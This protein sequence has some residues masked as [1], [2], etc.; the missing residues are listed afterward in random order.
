MVDKK[1]LEEVEEVEAE[2]EAEESIEAEEPSSST[3]QQRQIALLEEAVVHPLREDINQLHEENLRMGRRI[4]VLV[5]SHVEMQRLI[6]AF[7]P[8]IDQPL[9]L[10]HDVEFE[11]M[12]PD[13]D[14]RVAAQDV[15]PP[16]SQFTDA[17]QSALDWLN[18]RLEQ[19]DL[20][21]VSA[22][23]VRGGGVYRPETGTLTVKASKSDR[24][25]INW[26]SLVVDGF[27][28]GIT[29]PEGVKFAE[30]DTRL[31]GEI[32]DKAFSPRG[33]D[34][35]HAHLFAREETKAWVANIQELLGISKHSEALPLFWRMF[36]E[37]LTPGQL[38]AVYQ[39]EVAE[40]EARQREREA[41]ALRAE[42]MPVE[43]GGRL[44]DW[45][46]YHLCEELGIN[47]PDEGTRRRVVA[48]AEQSIRPA[49]QAS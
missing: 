28:P 5:N 2:I 27:C 10:G 48:K 1:I 22:G 44:A 13:E 40:R 42:M 4:D 46:M 19:V 31:M 12:E 26:P 35:R 38:L 33:E 14:H 9:H 18:A 43:D 3:T 37:E 7:R 16:V 25:Y 17:Q 34:R 8:E 41:E 20:E 30:L 15:N 32:V 45:S 23:I 11:I 21:E 6:A 47:F 36:S 29:V 24:K 49:Q 39:E